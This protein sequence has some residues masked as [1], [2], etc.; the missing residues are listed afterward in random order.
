LAKKQTKRI[1]KWQKNKNVN[2]GFD[3]N[4]NSEREVFDKKTIRIL[5]ALW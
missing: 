3:K 5:G 2:A 4:T 1:E